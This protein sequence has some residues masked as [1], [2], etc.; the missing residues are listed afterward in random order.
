MDKNIY[1]SGQRP[2][3]PAPTPKSSQLLVTLAPRDQMFFLIQ[4]PWTPAQQAHTHPN[5][6]SLKHQYQIFEN[7]VQGVSSIFTPPPLPPAQ[8]FLLIHPTLCFPS[9]LS[10]SFFFKC[11]LNLIYVLPIYSWLYN[12]PVGYGQLTRTYTIKQNCLSLPQQLLI[13]QL[14]PSRGGP[15]CLPVLSS[16]GCHLA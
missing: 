14:F 7:L 10:F 1:H 15:L 16:L 2:K 5:S 11:L 3:F 6:K 8:P 4:P 9:S 13:S 12:F